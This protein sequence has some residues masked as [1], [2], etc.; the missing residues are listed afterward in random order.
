MKSVYIPEVRLWMYLVIPLIVIPLVLPLAGL[1]VY[2]IRF[3]TMLF[4]WI[5]LAESWNTIYGYAGRVDFGHVVFFGIGAY[6]CGLSLL[7]WKVNVWIAIALGAIISVLI[8]FIIGI[9]TLRLGGAYFAI[10]TWAF[11]E[12]MKQ[13]C[14]VL[15]V[16][17]GA[18]GISPP[19]VLTLTQC[20]YLMYIFMLASV[21]TNFLIERSKFGY[22]LRAL[23]QSEV[24]AAVLG[25]DAFKYRLLAF[26]ISALFPGLVGGLYGI[27]ISYV[28]PYDAFEALKTDQM[29]A[30]TLIGGAGSWLGPIIG[31]VLIVCV[32][33]VLWTYWSE[34]VY[35]IVLGAM[36]AGVVLF[37]PEGII[38]VAKRFIY[39]GTR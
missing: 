18:Y 15:G 22:G 4:M 38:S 13:L 6:V 26:M 20:Y 34:I 3:L 24:A 30:M 5:A 33:E 37:M 14:L 2:H 1:S 25:V 27:W 7:F 23:S 10:S 8:A 12:A 29:V 35:L 17:G 9:P 28:Y 36:I 32:L 39:K 31:A 19:P 16:T 21:V 11:A